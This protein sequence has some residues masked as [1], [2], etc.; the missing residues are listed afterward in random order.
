MSKIVILVF[1]ALLCLKTVKCLTCKRCYFHVNDV[2]GIGQGECKVSY[3]NA[4]CMTKI[5]KRDKTMSYGCGEKKNCSGP[6]RNKPYYIICC[7]TDLCNGVAP[8]TPV[9]ETF[10]VPKFRGFVGSP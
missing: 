9:S 10:T 8:W 5:S 4:T 7:D 1:C 3:R 2:C 6:D